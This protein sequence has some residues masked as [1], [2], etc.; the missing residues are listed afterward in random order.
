MEKS[1]KITAVLAVVSELAYVIIGR[2]I[3]PLIG[4]II[5]GNRILSFS[6]NPVLTMLEGMGT[7]YLVSF[8]GIIIPILYIAFMLMLIAASKSTKRGIVPEVIGIIVM[9]AVMPI[10]RLIFNLIVSTSIYRILITINWDDSFPI[11]N[12]MGTYGGFL[13][14]LSTFALVLIT[15]SF[16]V[17]ICR[18][19]TMD[20]SEFTEE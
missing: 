16:T 17:S 15:I 13:S 1:I 19:K 11:Y 6:S 18:K 7:Y 3:V 12:M 8:A 4:G 10:L 20:I 14:I 2:I 9:G 5:Y